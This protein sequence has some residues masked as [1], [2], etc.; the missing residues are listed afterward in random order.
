MDVVSGRSEGSTDV[1]S[2]AEVVVERYPVGQ[3]NIELSAE[4]VVG[5]SGVDWAGVELPVTVTI[6]TEV[7][8]TYVVPTF[9]ELTP[10]FE[11]EHACCTKY[12]CK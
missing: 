8:W 9:P 2:A 4:V 10:D 5:T 12:F 1:K 7:G 11:L 6:M 3:K